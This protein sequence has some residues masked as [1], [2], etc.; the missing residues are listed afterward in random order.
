[1]LKAIHQRLLDDYSREEDSHQLPQDT[2]ASQDAMAG[3]AGGLAIQ[4]KPQRGEGSIQVS[5]L[6]RMDY[7]SCLHTLPAQA[8]IPVV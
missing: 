6:A 3:G 8:T 5:R 1:M 7:T 4:P 2:A